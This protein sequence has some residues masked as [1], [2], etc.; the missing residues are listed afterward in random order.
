MDAI[1]QRQPESQ[2]VGPVTA[3]PRTSTQVA[4]ALAAVA[5][6]GRVIDHSRGRLDMGR[7]QPKHVNRIVIAAIGVRIALS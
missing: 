1:D 4:A 7:F 6:L 5:V 2:R 3:M